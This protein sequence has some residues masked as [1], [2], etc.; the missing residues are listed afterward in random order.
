MPKELADARYSATAITIHWVAAVLIV[1]LGTI[2]LRLESMPRADQPYWINV[3]GSVGLIYLA[4]VLARITWRMGHR[5]PDL[6][7]DVGEFSRR[8]SHPIH[9]LMYALMLAI[10]LFGIVA[11][12]WHGRAFDYGVFKLDFGIASNRA[13]FHPAEDVHGWLAYVLFAL[14]GLHMLAALWHHIVRKDGVL[15]RMLPGG[16]A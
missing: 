7:P 16:Q 15:K 8:T 11:F 5:P 9:M 10:P 14:A 12:V 1:F 4:I 6:P 2:G 3:H 13:I